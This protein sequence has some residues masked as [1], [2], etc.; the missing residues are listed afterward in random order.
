M[1]A[2]ALP[3]DACQSMAELRAQIDRVDRALLDLLAERAGFIDR[4]IVLKP[5]ENL[6]AR[7]EGRVAEVL[8]NVRAG[9][10]ERGLDPELMG[11]IWH[12]LIEAAIAHE[13]RVLGPG[14][15]AA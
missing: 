1:N 9:A 2:I 11:R 4:A 5:R 13:A 3:P 12:E 15:D 6:P 14:P 7:T 10:I 8:A